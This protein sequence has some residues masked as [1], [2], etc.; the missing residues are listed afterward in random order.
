MRIYDPRHAAPTTRKRPAARL[1]TLDGAVI[2]IVNNGKTNAGRLLELV[3]AELRREWSIKGVVELG[4]PSPGYGGLPEDVVIA[5]KWADAAITAVGDCGSCSPGSVL[6]AVLFE[7]IGIPAVPIVT[8]PF[9]LTA[10]AMA[11][12]HGFSPYTIVAIGHPIA[13]L[14]D[15]ELLR[16]ARVAAPAVA[17]ALLARE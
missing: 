15:D 12:L 16:R 5:A 17:A 11:R 7:K 14:A 3:I 1:P 13:S 2:A 8:A 10:T 9:V 6:D 4:P